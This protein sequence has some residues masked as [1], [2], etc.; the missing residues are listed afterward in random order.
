MCICICMYI[1]ARMP[2]YEYA[3]IKV[4]LGNTKASQLLS[5]LSLSM[6]AGRLSS[7][8]FVN[9][10][11]SLHTVRMGVMGTVAAFFFFLYDAY[12]FDYDPCSHEGSMYVLGAYALISGFA[13]GTQVCVGCVR[14]FARLCACM[15]LDACLHADTFDLGVRF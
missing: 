9:K 5:L 7:A 8:W 10:I 13:H 15:G 14:I 4:G 2:A 1:Y 12:T 3:F 6:I 11:G